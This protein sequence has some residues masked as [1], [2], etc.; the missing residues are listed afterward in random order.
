MDAFMTLLTAW[1]LGRHQGQ[2]STFS[3]YKGQISTAL[4]LLQCKGCHISGSCQR[5]F[6]IWLNGVKFLG[7]GRAGHMGSSTC[8]VSSSCVKRHT[9][10]GYPLINQAAKAH[11]LGI[12]KNV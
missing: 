11:C 9:R 1:L 2:A 4:L 10:W 5:T 7:K 8:K 12:P 6:D 3:G